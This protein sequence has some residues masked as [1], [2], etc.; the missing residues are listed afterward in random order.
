MYPDYGHCIVNLACS[1]SKEF[2][3]NPKNNTLPECD[4]L[5]HGQ[6]NVVLLLLDGMGTCIMD[7]ILEPDGFFRTHCIGSISS[8][9]PPTTVAATTSL[10][11]GLYPIQHSWLGWDCYFE[12]LG[13]NVSVFR[14]M[15]SETNIPAA[16]YSVAEKFIPYQSITQE[17]LANGGDARNIQDFMRPDPEN[18][19]GFFD[20]IA[21]WCRESGRKY[22]YA[23]LQNPDRTMHTHGCYSMESRRC[24]SRI[25]STV[26][27]FSETVPDTLLLI[28]PDH[29]HIDLDSSIAVPEDLVLAEFLLRPPSLEP[30][31]VNFFIKEG[32]Q[33]E[34]EEYFR[35]VYG[36]HFVLFS[37]EDICKKQLFGRGTPH[38]QFFSMLGDY[39]AAGISRQAIF[40]TAEEKRRFKGHHTGLLADEMIVPLI[41]AD[42]YG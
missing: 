23:Y 5:F 18:L 21:G 7:L 26:R 37:R 1:I 41:A 6:K 19:D 39:I 2:G 20:T 29:G 27:H 14:N 32:K 15:V 8:V 30:R 28:T 25:E 16:D 42:H 38:P 33:L 24:L 12:Q 11:S 9:F 3:L 13:K 36:G 17:I 10:R 31:A 40:N 4:K 22:I 35:N 34:F